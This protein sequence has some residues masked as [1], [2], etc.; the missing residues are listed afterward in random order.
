[1]TFSCEPAVQ[2]ANKSVPLVSTGSVN[3]QSTDANR[4]AHD[5]KQAGRLWPGYC[6]AKPATLI[7]D[8]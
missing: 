3:R 8:I 4:S 5:S 1:M 6:V 2:G 7:G